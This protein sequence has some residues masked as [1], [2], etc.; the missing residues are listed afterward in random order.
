MHVFSA[1]QLWTRQTSAVASRDASRRQG[2]L[3]YLHRRRQEGIVYHI[4]RRFSL[5]SRDPTV[6][7][8]DV[9]LTKNA[10]GTDV[11][12]H[13]AIREDGTVIPNAGLG[14]FARFTP[15]AI[16]GEAAAKK[17]DASDVEAMD[18]YSIISFLSPFL[19]ITIH[20]SILTI[21]QLHLLTY[22]IFLPITP[23]IHESSSIVSS[24][25]NLTH[26]THHVFTL[27]IHRIHI[28]S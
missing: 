20:L 12:W 23:F 11:G 28:L 2:V 19:S 25:Y 7:H 15:I 6:V 4:Q 5:L 13:L 27:R 22:F 18:E 14:P 9:Y 17:S 26:I 21:Y 1:T 3:P 8:S 16:T 10:V 24:S